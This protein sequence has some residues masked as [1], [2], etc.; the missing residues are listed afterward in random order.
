MTPG[1]GG[2]K[3]PPPRFGARGGPEL[4]AIMAIVWLEPGETPE[5]APR[6]AKRG[7]L[8]GPWGRTVRG[9]RAAYARR[10]GER[11]PREVW[12]RGTVL[13]A[14]RPAVQLELW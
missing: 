1:D 2:A 10:T 6:A 13:Y 3:A 9:A 12:L 11:L 14:R 7:A 8:V 4:G 5:T